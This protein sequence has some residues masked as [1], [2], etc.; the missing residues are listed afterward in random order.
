LYNLGAC[1]AN[2]RD[3]PK[4]FV[5]T[6]ELFEKAA[7]QGYAAAQGALR[8]CYS[9]GQGVPKNLV[10]AEEWFEKAVEQGYQPPSEF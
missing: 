10:K 3:V 7:E 8:A 5:K 2:G 6:I 1:Y 9:N 4:N